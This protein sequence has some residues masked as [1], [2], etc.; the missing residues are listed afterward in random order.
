MCGLQIFISFFFEKN[1]CLVY[2][3]VFDYSLKLTS[4]GAPLNIK[5]KNKNIFLTPKV[6]SNQN[7]MKGEI[8]LCANLT[9]P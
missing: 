1:V 5:G 6:I 2:T 9:F 4:I 3:L 7:L 8:A